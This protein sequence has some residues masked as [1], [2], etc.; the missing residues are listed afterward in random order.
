MPT[1]C[2]TLFRHTWQV[3][4]DKDP[5]N[6][7]LPR[8]TQRVALDAIMMLGG[9]ADTTPDG[10][11]YVLDKLTALGQDLAGRRAAE[12]LTQ[13]HYRQSARDIVRYLENPAANAPKSASVAWGSHSDPD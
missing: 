10:R 7:A 11:S 4:K 6:A 2:R 13:P 3:L 9:H 1:V 12:P 5:H 8:V